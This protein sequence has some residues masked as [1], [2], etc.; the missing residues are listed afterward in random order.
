MVTC[1]DYAQF[2]KNKLKTKIK[3]MEKKPVLAII[4][5]GDNQASN[6]YVKG[7]IKDCE[8]VGI[9]CIVSKL[10]KAIEEHE[11]LY[12]IELTTCV[13]DGIIVQLPL[14]KHINVEHVKNAIPKEKDV[15]GFRQDSKFDCCTPK[16]I[17]DWLYFNGYDV[18][19]K[20]VVVLGRS[21]I[22]GK[23]L[24]NMLI[25]R[26]ATVTCCNSHT[27]YGYET[28][29]TNNDADVIVSAIGKAK[30]LD[31]EDIGSDCEIV[32]DVGI[33]RDDA[34]KLCGDVNRESVEKLRPD[35]YVTPV[36]GGVGLLTR[37]SLLKNVVEAHENG[38][39]ENA[40]EDA[41][42]LLRKNDYFVRKIP[43][44]LCETAKECS[45]TG[46]GECLDCSCFACMIGNE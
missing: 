34:G 19:G 23:P 17:I 25:D 29:I 45:E 20:N 32:I 39:T 13:A 43:K 40:V 18:C 26:G 46:C 31:W 10:D 27:D 30:F 7:K 42:S 28:Q 12:H 41:I 8:E 9:R 14:P 15:D 2:V 3:G 37:V 44:N 21:E 38:Y 4:Q 11:L 36:P 33:N 1:K 22:V 6:S 24:V 35:T 16:G 5:V